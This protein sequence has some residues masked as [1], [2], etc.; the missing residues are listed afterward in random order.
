MN[1]AMLTYNEK[2]LQNNTQKAFNEFHHHTAKNINK[3][4]C[5]LTCK[6][7][8]EANFENRDGCMYVS[9]SMKPSN[10]IMINM[11]E[12]RRATNTTNS[13]G[14][15]N[16]SNVENQEYFSTGS[17]KKGNSSV[18][19]STFESEAT[20]LTGIVQKM[21]RAT[22]RRKPISSPS[23]LLLLLLPTFFQL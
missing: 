10:L 9:T 7:V 8:K 6:I 21:Q 11:N 16:A 3:H 5:W 1:T 19:P 2:C 12:G 4:W 23:C 15:N 18:S 22:V 14:A 20:K 17:F 13:K